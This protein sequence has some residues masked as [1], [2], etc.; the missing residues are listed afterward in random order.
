V[1]GGLPEAKSCVGGVSIELDFESKYLFGDASEVE[2]PTPTRRKR[3]DEQW[4]DAP[5]R[6]TYRAAG[7]TRSGPLSMTCMQGGTRIY[8]LLMKGPT[9]K[10]KSRA[11]PPPARKKRAT[12]YTQCLVHHHRRRRSSYRSTE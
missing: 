6:R 3:K 5:G 10:T 12:Q 1:A 8:S 4:S 9:T 2:E 11:P 7:P